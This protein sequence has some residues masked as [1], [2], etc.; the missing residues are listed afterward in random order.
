MKD[1]VKKII[2]LSI[3]TLLI[4]T[5]FATLSYAQNDQN[6]LDTYNSTANNSTISNSTNNTNL[7][8]NANFTNGSTLAD[9]WSVEQDVSGSIEYVTTHN[10][11]SFCH[12]GQSGDDGTRKIKIYQAPITGVS[13][14]DKIKFSILVSGNINSSRTILGIGAFNSSAKWIG[15]SDVDINVSY[16]PQLYQVTYVCPQETNYVAVYLDCLKIN[17]NSI[18]D[19]SLEK[20]ELVRIP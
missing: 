18:I 12:R 7:L 6:S 4:A 20:A 2:S 15:E 10:M 1:D 13:A 16:T 3:T 14:G 8:I 19:L 5:I 9:N 11:Q 17:P